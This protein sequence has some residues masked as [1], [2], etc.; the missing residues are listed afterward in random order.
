MQ[1]IEREPVVA[2]F[3]LHPP[4]TA[5]PTTTTSDG[6]PDKRA[7][8]SPVPSISPVAI[9][10]ARTF[11]LIFRSPSVL[12]LGD[13][14]CLASRSISY[15]VGA[16]P[17]ILAATEGRGRQMTREPSRVH[18]KKSPTTCSSTRSEATPCT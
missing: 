14:S 11:Q 18:A 2:G 13:V 12:F 15:G 9:L 4:I 17:S 3:Q 10:R 1:M 8:L 7:S 16:T 6:D 5:A